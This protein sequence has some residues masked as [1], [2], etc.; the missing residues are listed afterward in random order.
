MIQV[1]YYMLLAAVSK[2]SLRMLTPLVRL[3]TLHANHVGYNPDQCLACDFDTMVAVREAATT[4][5]MRV[6]GRNLLGPNLSMMYMMD[7]SYLPAQS[8]HNVLLNAQ[9]AQAIVL[10]T[11]LSVYAVI[12]TIISTFHQA[13]L[14]L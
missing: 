14:N 3:I 4:V 13:Y 8:V 11:V 2:D 9:T 1:K 5:R 10:M 7:S 6:L 12:L